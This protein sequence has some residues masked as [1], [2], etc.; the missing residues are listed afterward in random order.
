METKITPTF[1]ALDE[2]KN[3]KTQQDRI[4]VNGHINS[5]YD[6]V[7]KYEPG[8]QLSPKIGWCRVLW[9]PFDDTKWVLKKTQKKIYIT[10]NKSPCYLPSPLLVIHCCVFVW[11]LYT[12]SPSQ[13]INSFFGYMNWQLRLRFGS[14]I[15]ISNVH[16]NP[17]L[18][19][20]KH[21]T[22]MNNWE[23]EPDR[24]ETRRFP[25]S[26]WK[27]TKFIVIV[28]SRFN[29]VACFF[30]NFFPDL[31]IHRSVQHIWALSIYYCCCCCCYCS[32]S[33]W[34]KSFQPNLWHQL[35]FYG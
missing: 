24:E 33:Y 29:R 27:I 19:V 20:Y 7:C 4:C 9:F 8:A 28:P 35:L 17:F 21:K 3:R 16:S 2:K 12:S 18:F 32:S 31:S 26:F 15:S 1:A 11:L 25:L 34:T 30:L 5:K 6:I 22:C 14:H 23:R 13:R 10:E